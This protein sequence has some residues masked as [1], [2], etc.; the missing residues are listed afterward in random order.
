MALLRAMLHRSGRFFALLLV[1]LMVASLLSRAVSATEMSPRWVDI[2]GIT[3][4]VCAPGSDLSH[5]APDGVVPHGC[6]LCV[7]CQVSALTSNQAS[8]RPMVFSASAAFFEAKPD[9][10]ALSRRPGA[11]PARGPPVL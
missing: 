7:V 3:V 10:S 11:T 2:G 6:D 9:S 1:T 5:P 4:E 8:S